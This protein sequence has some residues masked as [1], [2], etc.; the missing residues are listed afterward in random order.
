M[1]TS[2]NLDTPIL[3]TNGTGSPTTP[4][5]VEEKRRTS[6]FG[7]LGG[8]KDRTTE[9]TGETGAID[10]ETKQKPASSGMLGGLFRR[11][12]RAA[13]GEKEVNKKHIAS[14]TIVDESNT[15]S[16]PINEIPT[17]ITEP[18]TTMHETAIESQE[19]GVAPTQNVPVHAAA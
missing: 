5:A 10:G 7:S 18:T 11:P 13:R 8:K 2:E 9:V 3:G 6:L 17:T 1:T 4:D 19:I 15:T 12:S 14:P 16:T